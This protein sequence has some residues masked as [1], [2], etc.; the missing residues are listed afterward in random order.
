MSYIICLRK[1]LEKLAKEKDCGLIGEWIR[2]VV[3][4]LYLSVSSTDEDDE[5][6]IREKWL[7]LNNHIHDQHTNHGKLYKKC[8]HGRL[9]RKWFKHS[10]CNACSIRIRFIKIHIDSKASEKVT[11]AITNTYLCNN[12]TKLS[13]HYQTSTLEAFHSLIIQF[14]PKDTAYSYNGMLAWYILYY[15]YH[16]LI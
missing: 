14:A 2:S 1:K 7:S 4:H 6:L 10:K 5:D 15:Y 9:R 8:T 13:T 11:A 12:I 16:G 3:N